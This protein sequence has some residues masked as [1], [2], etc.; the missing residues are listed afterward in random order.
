MI[1][2]YDTVFHN[3]SDYVDCLLK[4]RIKNQMLL[5][6][7]KRL[8]LTKGIAGYGQAIIKQIYLET[9][10]GQTKVNGKI[11]VRAVIRKQLQD[12]LVKLF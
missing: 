7:S 11:F 1:I 2:Q 3:A 12:Y 5:R 9:M 8:T 10:N 4:Y 6:G